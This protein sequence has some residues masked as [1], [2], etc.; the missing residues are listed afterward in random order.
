[1]SQLI[2]IEKDT[3]QG[4]AFSLIR[5]KDKRLIVDAGIII[6]GQDGYVWAHFTDE[7]QHHKKELFARLKSALKQ[8]IENYK[9][10]KVIA[11]V[12][13]DLMDRPKFIDRLGFNRTDQFITVQGINYCNYVM[14]VR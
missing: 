13:V 8:V 9:L 5:E 4:I 10:S 12:K 6:V 3:E 1:M 2:V 7:I 14:E 11:P